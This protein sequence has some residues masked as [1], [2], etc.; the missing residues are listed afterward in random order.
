MK[1]VLIMLMFISISDFA[2]AKGLINRCWS[3]FH[4]DPINYKLSR[5]TKWNNDYAKDLFFHVYQT[6]PLLENKNLSK[7]EIKT[8]IQE[9]EST[10]NIINSSSFNG[11]MGNFLELVNSRLSVAINAFPDIVAFIQKGGATSYPAL[12]TNVILKLILTTFSRHIKVYLTSHHPENLDWLRFNTI[13]T[14]ISEFKQKPNVFSLYK[15]KRA[16]REK[17]S[18]EQYINCK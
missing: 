6:L 7:K 9:L 1:Y 10:I 15:I 12:E 13:L 18:L 4:S 14:S 16:V 8:Y 11:V 3:F 17:Y 5:D 2:S